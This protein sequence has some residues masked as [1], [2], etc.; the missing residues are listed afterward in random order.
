MITMPELQWLRKL[1]HLNKPLIPDELWQT[2][3]ARF[4]F[5]RTLADDDLQRLK[6]LSEELLHTKTITGAGGLEITDEIAVTI[7]AQAALL[8]LNL[9]L[10]LYKDMPGIVVYPSAFMVP[11][12]QRDAAG[13]VHEWREALAGQAMSAG[14][15][16]ALSWEDIISGADFWA[17]R[18]VVIHEFAHK[19]DMERGNPN[20]CPP[21]LVN[22]HD[23][24]QVR[25][26]QQVFSAAFNDF[27]HRVHGFQHALPAMHDT[28][29][30][31]LHHLHEPVRR[32]LPLDPYA[33]TNPAEFFAVASEVFFV[34][35]AQ[36][37]A[38]YPQVY[39]LLAR[40]YRQE[41][42]A[43]PTKLQH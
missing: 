29:M 33:S 21:F 1:L 13:V 4:P 5:I 25:I 22:Y 27:S 15:T 32:P 39:H 19:I 18:N 12:Q 20:G 42:I 11:R 30:D 16:I 28:Q 7:V 24:M 14:G 34:A 38:D 37:I 43:Y 2:C 23:G 9:T 26:W 10:D 6:L 35:P 36:L 40:Y 8:V 31:F 17:R 41:T 3:I